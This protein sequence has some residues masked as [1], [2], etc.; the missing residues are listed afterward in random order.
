[1]AESEKGAVANTLQNGDLSTLS[2]EKNVKVS[3]KICLL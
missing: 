2:P 3:V 1:M